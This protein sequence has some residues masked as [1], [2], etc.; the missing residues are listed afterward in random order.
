MHDAGIDNSTIAEKAIFLEGLGLER[1]DVAQMLGT[2]PASI[3]EL[4][5]VARKK[6]SKKGAKKHAANKRG[7]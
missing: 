7:R 2:S 3:A 1:A 5:R 6:S 4:L